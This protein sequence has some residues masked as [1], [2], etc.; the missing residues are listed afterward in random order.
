MTLWLPVPE[1]IDVT[2]HSGEYVVGTC[3][4]H[5]VRKGHFEIVN[6]SIS[7]IPAHKIKYQQK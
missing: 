2:V 3:F 7:T 4:V 6:E 5:L 1:G